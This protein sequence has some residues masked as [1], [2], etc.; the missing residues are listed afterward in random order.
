[1]SLRPRPRSRRRT[2]A[3]PSGFLGSPDRRDHGQPGGN[4]AH[5]VLPYLPDVVIQIG[6]A[7]VLPIALLAGVHGIALA[8]RAGGVRQ[9]LLLGGQRCCRHRRRCFCGELPGAARSGAS[10]RV[11][12]RDRIGFPGDHRHGSGRQQPDAGCARRQTSRPH[13]RRD[14]A[15]QST[16]SSHAEGGPTFGA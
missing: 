13:P 2:T 7:A 16:N 15:R 3:G 8:V 9:G 14:H 6:A 11:Q 12:L 4:I 1:M 10:H 5:A